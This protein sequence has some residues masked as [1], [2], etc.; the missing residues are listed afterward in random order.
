MCQQK[1]LR[2]ILTEIFSVDTAVVQ[3]KYSRFSLRIWHFDWNK[4]MK[5]DWT[6]FKSVGSPWNWG[7]YRSIVSLNV[8]DILVFIKC[9]LRSRM[10]FSFSMR[11]S[12]LLKNI[13]DEMVLNDSWLMMVSK[14][15][16][17]S[18]RRFLL[19]SSTKNWSY[20]M[21]DTI[22]RI[23][24]TLSRQLSHLVRCA[25]CP[26][27]SIKTKG[28]PFIFTENSITDFVGTLEWRISAL[29]GMYLPDEILFRLLIK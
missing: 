22:K 25:R 9:F 8:S 17:D 23:D 27:T 16:N 20:S 13:I 26:P 24:E 12:V 19:R 7:K 6:C 4:W 1:G 5:N 2:S 10:F 11:R 18:S 14:I 28:T 15:A 3:W 29:V 21:E